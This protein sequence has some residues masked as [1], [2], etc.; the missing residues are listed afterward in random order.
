M[1][2]LIFSSG[3]LGY[4]VQCNKPLPMC[5]KGRLPDCSGPCRHS[6]GCETLGAERQIGH[7]LSQEIFPRE[8]SLLW[9]PWC[10]HLQSFYSQ[11]RPYCLHPPKPW[12]PLLPAASAPIWVLSFGSLSSV[13]NLVFR[14]PRTNEAFLS[15]EFFFL[16]I[17]LFSFTVSP[18]AL[19]LLP[20]PPFSFFFGTILYSF[21]LLCNQFFIWDEDQSFLVKSWKSQDIDNLKQSL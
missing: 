1:C 14:F 16:D 3:H 8:L 12:T 15:F 19:L 18:S 4:F 20:P 5:G 11:A 6:L 21:W 13:P 2:F 9:V 10:N 17:H 7:W